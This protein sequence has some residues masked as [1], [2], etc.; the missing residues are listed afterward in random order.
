MKR[1]IAISNHGQMVGGGEQSFLDLVSHLPPALW[2]VLAAVPQEGELAKHLRNRD[3]SVQVLALPSLRPRHGLL[4]LKALKD[5]V[6]TC[7]DIRPHLIYANGS[8]AALYGGIIGRVLKIPVIWH[9]RIA[10]PDIY[11]DPILCRLSTKIIANSQATARRFKPLFQHK[12][13]TVYNG[14]D[15]GWLRDGAV[16]KPDL[17]Q[18]DWKV[19][20]VVARVSKSKRHDLALSAFEKVAPSDPELHLVCVGAEDQLE[21]EWYNYLMNSTKQSQ[22]SD[23]IHWVG[24]V[25][26]IR[27]WYKSASVLLFPAEK[28]AFGRVLV[29][30]M[31]CGVPVV[32]TR[33]GGVS[34]IVTDNQDGFLVKPGDINEIAATMS[35]LLNDSLLRNQLIKSAIQRGEAFTVE[36]HAKEMHEIFEHTVKDRHN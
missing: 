11:L 25:A 20:L 18:S 23:R 10:D 4:I 2:E 36:L 16:K 24:Q 31:A 7:R 26:D 19:I 33:S 17:I 12:V 28:E 29:E 14:I 1:L 9:C 8:R 34:E 3:I 15:T 27:P 5:Y 22:F 32:A 21:P 6:H 13:R 30:A 35:A